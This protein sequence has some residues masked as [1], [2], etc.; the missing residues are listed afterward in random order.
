MPATLVPVLLPLPF[1]HP[2]DYRAEAPLAPGTLVRVGLGPRELVGAVWDGAAAGGLAHERIR[3]VLAVLDVPPLPAPLRR[4]VEAAASETLEPSGSFLRAVLST[5]AAL[6]PVPPVLGYRRAADGRPPRTALERRVLAALDGADA[7]CARTLAKAART[8]GPALARL[9]E[10]GLLEAVALAPEPEPEPDPARPGPALDPAQ[11]EAAA[12]LCARVAAGDGVVLLEG[13]PGSGKTE[14][15]FEAIAAA[16]RRGKR[17]LVLLPEIALT[18]QW[19]A[20][21][22]QRFGARPQLWHSGL[23]AAHRREGWRRIAQGRARVVVGARSAI[24]LP[25]SELGLIVVDEEHDPSFKQE[26]GTIYHARDLALLRGRLEGCPVVLVSATPSLE[27]AVAAGA[28]PE[29]PPARPGWSHLLLAARHGTAPPPSV[30]L[31]DLRRSP[32]PRGAFLAPPVRAALAEALARGEQA[33]LFLNRRG[34]APLTLCRACGHRL[35]CPNCT[36]WLT[37]HRLRRRLLCHHCGFSMAEPEHCPSCGG[38]DSLVASGPGVERIAQEA[39][40]LFPQ[41]RVRIVTSD[42]VATAAAAEEL[43]RA[44][45][46]GEVDLL[47]G[48]QML[49]KGHHFPALTLVVAVDADLGLSGGDPR[50]AER[51]FQLLFQVAGRAGRAD[52]PGRVLVQTHDPAHPVMQAVAR[53]DRERFLRAELAE[54]RA[55][56][57]PPFGRLAALVASGP[58]A[59]AVREFARALARAAPTAEGVEI[60]G[61]APA[62]LAL[63]RGR[64]R[65]RLLVR[66]KEGVDL[67]RF[68]RGWLA[69]RRL[70]PKIRLVVDVDPVSFL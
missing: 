26:E 33:L 52:R 40:S 70:P 17:V 11:A 51:G 58:Q 63:L 15:Y 10:S 37:A 53:A 68:L 29:G 42:T 48:T 67:P 4:L 49:A 18:A 44:V 66:A 6:E 56:G 13:V 8:S 5:P 24:F 57:L 38:V 20:R 32:P 36:A 25:L 65:E 41:A 46:A 12:R 22:E 34:F 3:P 69:G 28:V 61:P 31:V 1:D 60:L 30:E 64:W 21:F 39:Q 55:G 50:A 47:V 54:R 16:L 59:E 45:L 14:V 7:L 35:R 62:P 27:T 19:L 9:A 2:L 43:V 23:S